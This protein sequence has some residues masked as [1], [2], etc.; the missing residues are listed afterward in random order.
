MFHP[1]LHPPQGAYF[2]MCVATLL[3]P[4]PRL[5]YLCSSTCDMQTVLSGGSTLH[6]LSNVA[7]DEPEPEDRNAEQQGAG[8]SC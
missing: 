6:P 4:V 1:N 8:L 2:I 3:C 5:I 7:L